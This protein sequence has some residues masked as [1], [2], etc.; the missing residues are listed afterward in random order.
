MP[1]ALTGSDATWLIR[2]DATWVKPAIHP[3]WWNADAGRWDA[4]LPRDTGGS[5]DHY[6]AMG[7]EDG[8]PTYGPAI[9]S[10]ST[11][12]PDAWW[13]E[14]SGTLWVLFG[15][16]SS[17]SLTRLAYSAG[18]Y[19]VDSGFPLSVP[20]IQ[21]EQEFSSPI[22]SDPNNESPVALYR[23]P[24][25]DL[26]IANTAE[27]NDGTS[28]PRIEVNRSTDNGATWDTAVN[29][30]SGIGDPGVTVMGHVTDGGTTRLVLYSTR[31]DGDGVDAWS[32]DQDSVSITAG[33]WSTESLPS[34]VGTEQSDDHACAVVY[35]GTMYVVYKTTSPDGSEPLI[36]LHVR[37]S[38]GGWSQHTAV[39]GP[40]TAPRPTR[41]SIVID[42]GNDVM[43]L[44]YGEIS[45]SQRIMQMTADLIDLDI[46]TTPAA[47]IS[48]GGTWSRGVIASR[49]PVTSTT[50]LS[51]I[52]YE[53]G[54][55]DLWVEVVTIDAPTGETVV[56]AGTLPALTGSATIAAKA[57]A[58]LA[59]TLPAL[60]GNFS[61]AAEAGVQF[62]S[63]LPALSGSF[64]IDASADVELA[65]QL[66]SLEGSFA[67]AAESGVQLDGTLPAL[68]GDYS[69]AASSDV[70]IAGAFPPLTGSFDIDSSA[71][72][73]L[74]GTLP[75]LGGGFAI[76]APGDVALE[77]AL[78]A[79]EGSFDAAASADATLAGELP[80]LIGSVTIDARVELQLAG[81]LPAFIGDATIEASADMQ[82]AGVLP[83]LQG[84]FAALV[85]VGV[86]LDGALP[87]LGGGFAIIGPQPGRPS[88]PPADERP[89][90][91]G[92]AQRDVQ[93]FATRRELQP[94]G[95]A[96][97]IRPATTTRPI[98]PT[99]G[100]P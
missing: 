39:L 62:D 64:D 43:H 55:R 3:I 23:T 19:T 58:Q 72:A 78:P 12:R 6:V 95:V 96:R 67:V 52:A 42:S 25:G 54:N 89:I 30:D 87:A 33:N 68:A 79:L 24:N 10:Q 2:P 48:G 9:N 27:F 37:V 65:G 77:G 81:T 13:D 29:L 85:P 44:F 22:A 100:V 11:T 40:D 18:S 50:D 98:Q 14:S 35:D 60:T 32:I 17:T 56:F 69:I 88:Q 51:L 8:T 16:Q 94:D 36:G 70:E 86:T 84:S 49:E 91:P 15:H 31:N 28:D 47:L 73:E 5:D 71:D 83:V 59:G 74:A 7:I 63:I 45:G 20:G 97:P 1:V 93:P 75:A 57:D 80:A 34:P 4:I 76:S 66:P 26:W 99:I 53:G 82:L 61:V 41:P 21:I 92:A 90:Q 46:W 38:D